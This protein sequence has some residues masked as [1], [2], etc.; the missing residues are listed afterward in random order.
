MSV[1]QRRHNGSPF[2]TQD[3]C[4]SNSLGKRTTACPNWDQRPQLPL[5]NRPAKAP[6]WQSKS[7]HHLYLL[8]DPGLPNTAPLQQ[9]RPTATDSALQPNAGF[10]GE[11][12]KWLGLLETARLNSRAYFFPRIKLRDW[13]GTVRPA[14]PPTHREPLPH[15]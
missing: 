7:R 3:R 2:V 1:K 6:K 5:R 13:S 9:N 12:R 15:R 10:L 14:F 4:G 11:E 8:F